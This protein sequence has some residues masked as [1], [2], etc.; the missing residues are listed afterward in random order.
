MSNIS[1]D[2]IQ[3][4]LT[5]LLEGCAQERHKDLKSL[6][7][8]TASNLFSVSLRIL[9]DQ[10]LAEDCIQQVFINIWRNAG[11][12]DAKKAKA[13][14][15]MNT[16]A[17]NQALDILRRNRHQNLHDGDDALDSLEDDGAGQEQ[18]VSLLQDTS[19]LHQCLEEI[20]K[21]QRQCLELAY[22]D[23][24]SHQGVSDRTDIALGTVKTWIRR[25]LARLQTC[26][27]SI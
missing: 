25:G 10:S 4:T 7:E 11:S 2:D 9:K 27:S 13:K 17:R 12:Y 8:L 22:F 3:N 15:W 1:S 21:E 14:T 20:P 6:Y 19:R 18:Q 26:M 16:I 23:G 5:L 24:L